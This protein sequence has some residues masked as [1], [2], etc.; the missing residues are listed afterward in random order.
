MKTPLLL[1]F[2]L[3][4]GLF[5][6]AKAQI[7]ITANDMPAIGTI[8]IEARDTSSVVLPGPSGANQTWNF[9]T[10]LN[11]GK[12][13]M[14]FV[15]PNGTSCFGNFPTANMAV[16]G[17]DM[18][19]MQYMILNAG[20][21]Q[22]LGFCGDFGMGQI[23][24]LIFNPPQTYAQIPFTYQNQHNGTTSYQLVLP[25]SGGPIDSMKIVATNNYFG[26]ADGW[27]TVQTP[28]GTYNCLRK[29]LTEYHI[30]SIFGHD[31]LTKQW[32]FFTVQ[33]D[34]TYSYDFWTNNFKYPVLAIKMEIKDPNKGEPNHTTVTYLENIFTGMEEQK[35]ENHSSLFYPNPADKEI[36]LQFHSATVNTILICDLLGRQVD[37]ISVLNE[38]TKINTANYQNGIYFYRLM[39][40][41]N[42]PLGCGKWLVQHEGE[43]IFSPSKKC[44][45]CN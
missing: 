21:L 22:F 43:E 6:S 27:G 42:H 3:C 9:S 35:G 34:T 37:K 44:G 16:A 23:T 30:D 5:I 17:G 20:N 25:Q 13:T 36:N 19:G 1:C 32:N 45:C 10:L 4:F 2:A 26:D 33:Y 14:N 11:Q 28:K 38:N 41:N 12:D 39:D 18:V 7:T 15:S 29:K 24:N 31:T 40:K 8:V